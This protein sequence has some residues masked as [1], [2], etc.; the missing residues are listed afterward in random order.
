[1]LIDSSSRRH[2]PGVHPDQIQPAE[3]AGVRPGDIVA[4]VNGVAPK[5]VF[6]LNREIIRASDKRDVLLQLQRGGTVRSASVKLL[7]ENT[8]FNAKLV[9]QKLGIGIRQLTAQDVARLGLAITT[10]FVVTEIERGS[11]SGVSNA[12]TSGRITRK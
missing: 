10:G 11:G 12:E 6:M 8:V 3:K 2:H 5:S 4:R 7:P 1:M 9:K